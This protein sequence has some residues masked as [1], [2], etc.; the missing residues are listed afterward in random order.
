MKVILVD[1]DGTINS[2]KSGYTSDGDIPDEPVEGAQDSIARLRRKF[3]VIV[4]SARARSVE[5]KNAIVAWLSKYGIEVDGVTAVKIP[6]AMQIDDTSVTFDGKWDGEM[7]KKIDEFQSWQDKEALSRE[8]MKPVDELE[9]LFD[10]P[11]IETPSE[12]L[13]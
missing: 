1:F 5:G 8:V 4:F 12:D 6:A 2:Y 7:M 9:G 10:K 3:R 13:I 11:Q